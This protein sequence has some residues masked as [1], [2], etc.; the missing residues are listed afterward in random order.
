[1]R[2]WI[3]LVLIALLPLQVSWS[4][5]AEYGNHG[6]TLAAPHAERHA[7]GQAQ[8]EPAAEMAA[9][10]GKPMAADQTEAHT[11]CCDLHQCHAHGSFA[12]LT[13]TAGFMPLAV[14][15]RYASEQAGRV[16]NLEATRIERPKWA[17]SPIPS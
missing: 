8:D 11:A 12:A 16:R 17:A 15:A 10:Q 9:A 14:V 2:R 4:V 7:H 13:A 5:A 6:A 1:M 3:A